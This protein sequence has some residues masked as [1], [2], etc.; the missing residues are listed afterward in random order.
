M[1][2]ICYIF[3]VFSYHIYINS[4]FY[5]CFLRVSLLKDSKKKWKLFK[6]RTTESSSSTFR[7]CGAFHKIEIPLLSDHS[8][9]CKILFLLKLN[10]L[11]LNINYPRLLHLV[12]E[13]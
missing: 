12:V 5:K 2:A 4:I 7:Q 13:L 6:N 3:M 8:V 9:G 11:Y 1:D 10:R